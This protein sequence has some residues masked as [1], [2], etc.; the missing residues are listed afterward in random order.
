MQIIDVQLSR[1]EKNSSYVYIALSHYVFCF[2]L[3]IY[4]VILL[5]FKCVCLRNI[6]GG[7][8]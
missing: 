2:I 3:L 7:Y 4:A 8:E 5:V 1:E 6:C